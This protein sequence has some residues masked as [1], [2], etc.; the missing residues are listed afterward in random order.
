MDPRIRDFSNKH[1]R[2]Y[3]TIY[4]LV[5][6]SLVVWASI[7]AKQGHTG[8]ELA[9]IILAS[10]IF[11][12]CV[13]ILYMIFGARCNLWDERFLANFNPCSVTWKQTICLVLV[14]LTV[15][16][17]SFFIALALGGKTI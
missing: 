16:A 11:A 7:V 8:I 15:L 6:I 14:A 4:L 9:T 3:A 2:V 12:G 10:S 13:G 17:G 5:S 1:P